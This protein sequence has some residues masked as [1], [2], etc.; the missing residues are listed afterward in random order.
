MFARITE[1]EK[2]YIEKSN[3]NIDNIDL[4]KLME[5]KR[6]ALNWVYENRSKFNGDIL[7]DK[8]GFLEFLK[9]QEV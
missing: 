6:E 8:D 1:I 7:N 3:L 5:I 9:E 2:I 4:E